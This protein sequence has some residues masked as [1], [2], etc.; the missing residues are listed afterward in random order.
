LASFSE[1]IILLVFGGS[2]LA[3]ALPL[4]ILAMN[5]I[6][7]SLNVFL[8]NPMMA[9]GKLREYAI[10]IAFCAISNIILN[11]VLIPKYSY[12]GAAFATL[13]SEVAVFIGL[14]YLFNKFTAGLLY[15]KIK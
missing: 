11:F 9:W 7:V 3:A 15:L 5:V 2:Y 10:A 8:G 6:V 4:S 13:L 12:I 1:R 14:F